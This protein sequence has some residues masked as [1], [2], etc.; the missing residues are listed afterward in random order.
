MLNVSH[1][2]GFGARSLDACA[3]CLHRFRRCGVGRDC[4]SGR[5][6]SQKFVASKSA[7]PKRATAGPTLGTAL[8][9]RWRMN[10]S[11]LL[12]MARF[13]MPDPLQ[14]FTGFMAWVLLWLGVIYAATL[15]IGHIVLG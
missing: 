11:T 2:T 3:Y 1:K 9:R 4:K 8:L 15:T 6:V 12:P 10:V 14:S 5:D 13:N 7:T